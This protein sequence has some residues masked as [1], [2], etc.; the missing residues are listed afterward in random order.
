MKANQ[1]KQFMG[2]YEL[3]FLWYFL[4]QKTN[5]CIQCAMTKARMTSEFWELWWE[6]LLFTPESASGM[7]RAFN[8]ADKNTNLM[9]SNMFASVWRVGWT[10]KMSL[11]IP[12]NIRGITNV[13]WKPLCQ[14][15]RQLTRS[16]IYTKVKLWGDGKHFGMSCEFST[17]TSV[18]HKKVKSFGQT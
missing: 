2:Q 4:R 15:R 12:L 9:I 3:H 16:A 13:K 14:E 1:C 5:V 10:P 17:T 8:N 18:I 7:W 6:W 11:R